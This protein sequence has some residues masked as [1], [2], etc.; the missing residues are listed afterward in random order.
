M[1]KETLGVLWDIAKFTFERLT[2]TQ[3]TALKPEPVTVETK[4]EKPNDHKPFWKR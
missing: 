4:K 2:D 1:N 3:E